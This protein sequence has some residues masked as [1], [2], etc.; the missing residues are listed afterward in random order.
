[1]STGS[2]SGQLFQTLP[3]HMG[4][5]SK[6]VLGWI[7]PEVLEYGEPRAKFTLGQGSRPPKGTEAAVK[8]NLPAKRVRSVSRTAATTPGGAPTTRATPTSA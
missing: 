6:Y 5:W 3:T 4:A 8:V 2:H 1:M 7:E